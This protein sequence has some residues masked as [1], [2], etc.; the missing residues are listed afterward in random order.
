MRPGAFNGPPFRHRYPRDGR[1]LVLGVMGVAGGVVPFLFVLA[2][3][4]SR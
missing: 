3:V 4:A 2:H 1:M